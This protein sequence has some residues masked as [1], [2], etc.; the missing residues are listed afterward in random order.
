MCTY[1]A[2]SVCTYTQHAHTCEQS[3][4]TRL[5]RYR[6][7]CDTRSRVQARRESYAIKATQ[8]KVLRT[9]TRAQMLHEFAK[10]SLTT[11]SNY[12]TYVTDISYVTE[13]SILG[14]FQYFNVH[15]V[16]VSILQR[17]CLGSVDASVL[18]VRKFRRLKM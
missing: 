11:R 8:I 18:I 13:V 12:A 14:M 7:N 17:P 10:P 9:L 6:R 2:T 16:E 15:V 3:G 5:I 4:K 1:I